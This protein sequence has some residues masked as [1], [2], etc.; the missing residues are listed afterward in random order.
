MR[1]VWILL[2]MGLITLPMRAQADEP[3]ILPLTPGQEVSDTITDVATFDWWQL[4]LNAGDSLRVLM[5]ASDGLAPLIGI[6]DS[7]GTIIAR[8]DDGQI[9]TTVQL[10]FTFEQTGIYTV[11]ATRTGT[12]TGE[13]RG[14]YRLRADLMSET[15]PDDRYMA[16]T[17]RCNDIEVDALSQIRFVQ[18]APTVR[19]AI[20]IYGVDGLLPVFKIETAREG[21]L[22]PCIQS[23]TA[24]DVA[25]TFDDGMVS[26]GIAAAALDFD[27]TTDLGTLTVT[28]GAVAA[29]S[30]RYIAVI[31]GFTIDP[32]DSQDAFTIRNAPL[33]ARDF[34]LLAYM[35]GTQPTARLDPLIEIRDVYAC[36]DAGRRGCEGVASAIGMGVQTDGGLTVIGDRFDAGYAISA[37]DLVPYTLNFGSRDGRTTGIYALMLIGQS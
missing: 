4:E 24:S 8:S 25:L 32:A 7:N 1:F 33:P 2:F 30:G 35:I 34:G 12:T 28:F 29:I 36:D 21:D 18:D 19:Y 6:L 13:T 20:R 10:E 17:F 11:V 22:E 9:N 16:V 15:I 23:Q 31:E 37:G 5:T 27:S 26:E 3:S 14:S